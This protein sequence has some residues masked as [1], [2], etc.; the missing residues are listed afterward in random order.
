MEYSVPVVDDRGFQFHYG[1]IKRQIRV[2]TSFTVTLF[3]FHYGTIKSGTWILNCRHPCNFN[4]T[5]VRLKAFTRRAQTNSACNFN[6]TMVRLKDPSGH[7][8]LVPWL[9]QFHYGTI[10]SVWWQFVLPGDSISIP[11]W[12]D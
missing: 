11:L 12:Y 7:Y 9:F 10:K 5:M 1:T 2:K 3:Q 8:R 4:S 6:S